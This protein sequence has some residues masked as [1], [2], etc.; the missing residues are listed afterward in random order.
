MGG[1]V[2]ARVRLTAN[3]AGHERFRA[4]PEAGGSRAGAGFAFRKLAVLT[5]PVW[6]FYGMR[7]QHK[8]V[9]TAALVCHL[10]LAPRLVTSQ[11]RPE[12]PAENPAPAAEQS[13]QPSPTPTEQTTQSVTA[14]PEQTGG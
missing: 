13:A 9:I 5:C 3:G 6:S 8:F 2:G 4:S 11:A 7:S 14:V 12:Q 10:F 1:A